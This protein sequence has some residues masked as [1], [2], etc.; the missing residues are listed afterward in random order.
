MQDRRAL[1]GILLQQHTA[2]LLQL[3]TYLCSNIQLPSLVQLLI[4]LAQ[5]SSCCL[6]GVC[7]VCSKIRLMRQALPIS[8]TRSAPSNGAEIVAARLEQIA[9]G[10]SAGSIKF[11]PMT[12][13][14]DTVVFGYLMATP[15]HGRVD[16]PDW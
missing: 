12:R 11:N 2:T 6:Q 5:Q 14:R 9:R 8:A 16:V 10:D 3:S 13:L 15:K 7:A 1:C 4:C